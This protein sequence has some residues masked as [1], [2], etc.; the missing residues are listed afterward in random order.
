MVDVL[1]QE[2]RRLNMSRIQ[3]RNTNI[4]LQVRKL[5][6]ANGFRFR[7][8]RRDLPGNPDIVLAKYHACIF[9]HGCF[10]HGHSCSLFRLPATRQEFWSQKLNG[11]RKRDALVTQSLLEQGWRVL[12]I[13][14]CALRGP[15]RMDRVAFLNSCNAFLRAEPGHAATARTL[16]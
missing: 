11:N 9:V 10:W 12:T 16:P 6:Y 7:L 15:G 1:T 14:E 4:E 8:H 2:Q 3:G 13:W 5:L